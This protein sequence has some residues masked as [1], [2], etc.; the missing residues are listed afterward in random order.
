MLLVCALLGLIA[1]CAGHRG[2]GRY[3][4]L[5]SD[6]RP[7]LQL[8]HSGVVQAVALS[9]D[10]RLAVSGSADGL[11]KF[12]EVST[13]R[14]IYTSYHHLDQKAVAA[15][16]GGNYGGITISPQVTF[17][18]ISAKRDRLLSGAS[19][20]SVVVS[21]I[22]TGRLMRVY[23]SHAK[24]VN[25]GSF[26]Q[27]ATLAVTGDAGGEIRLWQT[28]T[29]RTIRKFVINFRSS[30]IT[31]LTLSPNGRLIL[32]GDS[33]GIIRLIDPAAEHPIQIL[34]Q[35]ASSVSAAKFSA[36]GGMAVSGSW[37]GSLKL[38]GINPRREFKSP[39]GHKGKVIAAAFHRSGDRFM[40]CSADGTVKLWNT[41]SK[42]LKTNRINHP[43]DVYA[44][45]FSSD[46][47][48][49]ITGSRDRTLKRSWIS[50]GRTINSYEGRSS[51]I[52]SVVFSPDGR[53]L[54]S[55]MRGQVNCWDMTTGGL[56][57][58][59]KATLYKDAPGSRYKDKH[60]L[61]MYP[62][63]I[64]F[65][66]DGR[67]VVSLGFDGTYHAWD[68]ATGKQLKTAERHATKL[69]TVAYSPDK[70]HYA[71]GTHVIHV[72]DTTDDRIVRTLQG[73][74]KQITA[75]AYSPDGRS[76]LSGDNGGNL[77]L[78]NVTLG[79]AVKKIH[80]HTAAVTS[81]DFSSAGRF[82]AAGSWDNTCRVWDIARGH[83]IVKL[84]ASPGGEWITSTPDGFYINSPEGHG[85]IHWSVPGELETYSFEQFESKYKR[86]DIIAER[87]SW[88]RDITLTPPDITK[89]PRI[90][91]K[92]QNEVKTIAEK[93]YPLQVTVSGNQKI[94]T[95][96]VF[97]NGKPIREIPVK[98]N[99][100]EFNL[101]VP[102]VFGVNR[103]TAVA[104][105]PRGFSSN[106]KFIDVVS[107]NPELQRPNLHVYAVGISRYARM[108]AQSQL[109]FAHTDARAIT[110]AFKNQEGKMFGVVSSTLLV[111]E[112]ATADKI[113]ENLC[114]TEKNGKADIIV[115]FLAGHGVKTSDGDYYFL[116]HNGTF[117][118]PQSDGLNWRR[119]K[120]C[121]SRATGRATLF[122]D[123][124]HSGSI[125]SETVVPNDEMAHQFFTGERAG[126]MVF[127]ASKGR[128]SAMESPDIGGGFGVFTWALTQGI[129]PKANEADIN[130]NQVVEFME[131]V[132]F[133][134]RT[135]N[136]LTQGAQTPW[137]SRK[138][139]FGD[140]P[141][142]TVE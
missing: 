63:S 26:S 24:G 59:F 139:L 22:K 34:G 10:N 28:A 123:A 20:G 111:N 51:R 41:A 79:I 141:I 68:L 87:L 30:Q 47:R 14:L 96:R 117:D 9:P 27:D 89:P 91:I 119:L 88:N 105:D 100:T 113:L 15:I 110:E 125:V 129:G 103:I 74:K 118:D 57:R 135:V 31:A 132:N 71:R 70:R 45:A 98:L 61:S 23:H 82:A 112:D 106:P 121:L 120:E 104:Y 53:Y 126:I 36:D 114:A 80:G 67:Q 50:T 94:E 2:I 127:T 42:I 62:N 97:L 56:R 25:A 92:D 90:E 55:S 124:C 128:Q 142:A 21:E 32:A 3:D 5:E 6:I 107:K 49:I 35:H 66:P 86:P 75:L 95:L 83:E 16:G 108:Q 39:N 78:W 99:Q 76:I 29:G 60:I 19:D 48:F 52:H 115:I 4:G 73:H 64:G 85:L 17:V 122:L 93:Q 116:G 84:I 44:A 11:L 18:D 46:G 37:D 69:S 140:L 81:I 102:L 77:I 8:G 109:Q 33:E 130:G 54:L 38:W 133:V 58:I 131:L 7:V 40:S 1:G 13:G 43:A 12:W 136:D 65:S 138:E 101:L 137:L 134:E 72:R